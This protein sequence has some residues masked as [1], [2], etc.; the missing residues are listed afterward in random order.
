MSISPAIQ[1]MR[2]QNRNHDIHSL[3]ERSNP[4]WIVYL[5]QWTL[6]RCLW[7]LSTHCFMSPCTQSNKKEKFLYSRGVQKVVKVE[8]KCR[9]GCHNTRK[10]QSYKRVSKRGLQRGCRS[11]RESLW[12]MAEGKEETEGKPCWSSTPSGGEVERLALIP[13]DHWGNSLK[14]CCG[15][16]G[17][18]ISKWFF[19]QRVTGTGT[20][21]PGQ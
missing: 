12:S 8:K 11:L 4:W 6:H 17:L 21:F 18:D 2:D 9:V 3:E 15:R 19:P 14:L 10:I 5:H 13:G 1:C 20:G 7:F 16:F